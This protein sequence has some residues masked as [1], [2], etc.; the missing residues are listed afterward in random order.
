MRLKY[1]ESELDYTTCYSI[2]SECV[3]ILL[4]HHSVCVPEFHIQLHRNTM[5][6][7]LQEYSEVLD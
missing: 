7:T 4:E 3:S 2:S 1:C 5:F 6:C